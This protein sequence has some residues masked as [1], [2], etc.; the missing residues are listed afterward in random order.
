MHINDLVGYILVGLACLAITVALCAMFAQCAKSF[1]FLQ[2]FQQNLTRQADDLRIHKMLGCLGM[3]TKGYVRKVPWSQV[4]NHLNKCEQ[5]AKTTECD[6]A[7]EKR[8]TSQAVD[9]C[10]NYSELVRLSPRG[11]RFAS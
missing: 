11:R 1:K 6:A 4:A 8:D 9:F 10:P 5:C 7:L 2:V 3:S